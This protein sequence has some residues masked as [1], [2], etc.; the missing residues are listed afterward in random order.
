MARFTPALVAV[1]LA[2]CLLG[3]CTQPDSESNRD[4]YVSDSVRIDEAPGR[5]YF[6]FRPIQPSGAADR[7]LIML[8]KQLFH[9]PRLSRDDTVSCASCH[10]VAAGGD[11]GR[12]VSVGVDGALGTHNAPTVLNSAGNFRQFWDGRALDLAEQVEGPVHNPLEM[13]TD[14]DSVVAKLATDG[15]LIRA[16]ALNEL[17]LSADSIVRAIVAYESALVTPDSPFDRWLLGQDDALSAQAHRGRELFVELGCVSC[18]QGRNVGGN[19]FQRFGVFRNYYEDRAEGA[20]SASSLGR[21]NVTGDDADRHV[22]KV[23]SLRNVAETAPYFHDGSVS[24]L[25][26]AID[27][28]ANYQLGRQLA[29]AEIASLESFLQS[30]SGSADEALL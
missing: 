17:D 27:I 6:G 22:F 21:F 9:D 16:F 25:T 15:E 20:L 28:M 19:M 1:V 11:D 10:I 7:G 30:L 13:A 29:K 3:G 5:D 18:H 24:T 8:G 14:W 23:P 26:E 2:F 4:P 12:P